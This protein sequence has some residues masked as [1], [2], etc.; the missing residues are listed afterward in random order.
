M[1]DKLRAGWTREYEEGMERISMNKKRI[2]I[3]IISG[4]SSK[5][6]PVLQKYEVQYAEVPIGEIHNEKKHETKFKFFKNKSDA[7]KWVEDPMQIEN[8]R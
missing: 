3:V 8:I 1:P 2:R 4:P 5:P 7:N 6:N